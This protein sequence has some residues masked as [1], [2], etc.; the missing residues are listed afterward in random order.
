MR[1]EEQAFVDHWSRILALEGLPPV[2]GRMWA[3]LLVCEPADQTAEQIAHAIGASRGAISGAARMLEPSGLILRTKRRGDRREY[4]RSAPDAVI[5]V[6]ET[7]ERQVRP[8]LGVLEDALAH[9][10]DRSEASLQRL[11]DTRDLYA[12]L[13][14]SFPAIVTQFKAERAAGAP[15]GVPAGKD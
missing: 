8:S 4:W 3:W 2:A 14:A 13:A 1:A 10:G 15:V 7:K 12:A 9:L 11:R 6:L 5:R